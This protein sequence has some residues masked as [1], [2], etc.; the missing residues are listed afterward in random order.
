[1]LSNPVSGAGRAAA[2]ADDIA[3]VLR[4]Q[5]HHVTAAHTSRNPPAE[6]LDPLLC[7]ADLLVIAG[8]DGAV[9]MACESAIRCQTPIYHLPMGT[10]NLFALEFGMDRD[11]QTLLR[12]IEAGTCR[13]V[14]VGRVLSPV[15]GVFALMAS[16]GFDAEV[17][18]ELAVRRGA[19]ISHLSYVLPILNQARRWKP[20]A[21]EVVVDGRQVFPAANGL[22]TGFV[23]IANCRRYGWRMNPADR[24]VMDDGLL[25]V[26]C[27][28]AASTLDVIRWTMKCIRR[29]QFDDPRF[30]YDR[31]RHISVRC[32]GACRYQIDGDPG[33]RA[34]GDTVDRPLQLEIEVWPSTLKVL[35]QKD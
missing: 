22:R 24:A 5:G 25:D 30:I 35:T 26:A 3:Q 31:G 6:W 2:A 4:S 7:D 14:D 18:S 29:R 12:A 1:M 9:R 8:G 13:T 27:F 32:D 23:V 16:V 28:P 17:V 34:I 15:P 11:P 10:E 19:S 20:P 21:L 33:H